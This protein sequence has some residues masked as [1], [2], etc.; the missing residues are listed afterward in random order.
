V[1]ARMKVMVAEAEESRR[2]LLGLAEAGAGE[3]VTELRGQAGAAL[4]WCESP[5]GESLAWLSLD[6]TGRIERARLRPGSFRNWRA[7][8]DAARSRNVFT[9]VPIIEASFWLTVAGFAR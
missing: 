5:R 1:L 3:G 6:D 7:F 2:L 8:D 4:G 9:D